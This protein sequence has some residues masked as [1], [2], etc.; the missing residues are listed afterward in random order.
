MSLNLKDIFDKNYLKGYFHR[1][2]KIFRVSILLFIILGS[3]G[4]LT[5]SDT[6]GIEFH[7]SLEGDMQRMLIRNQIMKLHW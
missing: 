4:T 6:M 3:I 5:N 7:K 1:N 2:K